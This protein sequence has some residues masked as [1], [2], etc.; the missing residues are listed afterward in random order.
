M[1]YE[2]SA[3]N[4]SFSPLGQLPQPAPHPTGRSFLLIILLRNELSWYLRNFPSAQPGGVLSLLSGLT[5][6]VRSLLQCQWD[7]FSVAEIGWGRLMKSFY[8][9]Q[10]LH[11]S[12][13]P[14]LPLA[15]PDMEGRGRPGIFGIRNLASDFKSGTPD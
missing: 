11:S 1:A 13:A 5:G 14:V 8:H 10:R 9:T 4:L 7:S 15:L 3:G 2:Y 6:N 12:L